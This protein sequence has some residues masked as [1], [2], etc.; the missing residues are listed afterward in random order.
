MPTL[1]W[2]R[3]YRSGDL[4]LHDPAGL[5]FVGRADEQVKLGGR[6]IE[7]GEVDAA[8][9]ALP[10]VTGAAAAVPDR[11]AGNQVLV[12]Y[13]VPRAGRFD[14]RRRPPG[15]APPS[16]PRSSRCSPSSTSSPPARP[17]RSTGPRCPGRSRRG[18][19]RGRTEPLDGTAA[20]LAEQWTEVLGARVAGDGRR[21]LR[22]R[23]RQPRRRPARLGPARRYP[24]ATVADVYGSRDSARWRRHLDELSPPSERRSRPRGCADAA[25]HPGWS[26]TSR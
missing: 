8:L 11:R 22:A 24:E 20:W 25:P 14:L 12:G 23:R 2:P 4:V 6:R 3:A 10:G 17:A 21:L 18:D 19:R 7:L 26:R 15:C 16:P 9:Q 13:L 5:L 1:G